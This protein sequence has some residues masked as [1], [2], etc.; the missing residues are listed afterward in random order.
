MASLTHKKV[1]GWNFLLELVKFFTSD[2]VVW[3]MTV[4]LCLSLQPPQVRVKDSSFF[5]SL[6]CFQGYI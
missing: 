5:F 1:L 2:G 6:L 4:A 3:K